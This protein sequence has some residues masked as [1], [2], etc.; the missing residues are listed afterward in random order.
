MKVRSFA[1]AVILSAS[2]FVPAVAQQTTPGAGNA[3]AVTLAQKSPI[4][5]SAF[6]FLLAQTD[7]LKD[8][9][10]RQQTE[11][12]IGN[13]KTCVQH[14]AGI[15][16]AK[17]AALLQQ[18]LAAGLVDP[19]DDATFPGGLLAGVFPPILNEGSACPQLP[20]AFYSAPG[21]V[22]G[23]HHSYPGGLPVHESNNDISDVELAHQYRLVYGH[24]R[25]GFPTVDRDVFDTP[26]LSTR[27]DIFID[28]DVIVGA[29]IWH[30]WAKSIVFQW[31]ADGT[32]FQ[33]LNFGGNGVTDANGAAGNSKTGGHHIM[34]V[35]EAMSRGLSPAFVITQACA[36]SAPTSGNEYKVVNWLRAAAILAQI[37]PV[38]AGY[39]ELDVAGHLLAEYTLH[40]LSDADFTYSGPAVTT[41]QVILQTLA[42][43]YGY[44]PAN[45]SVYNNKYRNP[46]LSFLTGERILILYNSQGLA[47]VQAQLDKLRS[48][49]VI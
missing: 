20:Q 29:P 36:H 11:D 7:S 16:P 24:S 8:R 6:R 13:P 18:L 5:Q 40:N 10:L 19:N 34:S 46:A 23:G 35:A 47:G 30:D 4:V 32:E 1:V 43:R 25:Q 44:D 27:S 41:A 49:G 37:D 14:R 9:H 42:V 22:F 28:Q 21:S 45:A 17:K 48:A 2:S 15:T 31:N 3:N 26:V 38:A 12:A 39:L 33:E